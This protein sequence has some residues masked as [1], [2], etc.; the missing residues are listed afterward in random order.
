MRDG[1]IT[2]E[3]AKLKIQRYCAYQERSHREVRT[4]LFSYGLR[5]GEVDDIITGLITDGYLNEERFARA[6]AGGKFRMKKWGRIRI[7]HA[8][9]SKGVSPNCIRIGLKEIDHED[10]IQTLRALLKAKM[11]TLDRDDPFVL[12]QQLSTYAI[13]KGYEPELVRSEVVELLPR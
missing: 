8:L 3:S 6:F 10:Y 2:P 13:R 1:A 12:R 5:S 11:E 9:E 7:T 4:K